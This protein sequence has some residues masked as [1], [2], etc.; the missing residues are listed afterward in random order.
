MQEYKTES[1]NESFLCFCRIVNSIRLLGIMTCFFAFVESTINRQHT[2]EMFSKL[3]LSIRLDAKYSA[4]AICYAHCLQS[5]FQNLQVMNL[6]SLIARNLLWPWYFHPKTSQNS[7][8]KRFH[9]PILI[10]MKKIEAKNTYFWSN[11]G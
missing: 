10:I 7:T 9:V 11:H 1:K 6:V 8:A 2:C 3:T 5:T 4:R